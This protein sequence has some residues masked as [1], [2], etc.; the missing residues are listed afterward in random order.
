MLRCVVPC[1]CCKSCS[2][3]SFPLIRNSLH[4]SLSISGLLITQNNFPIAPEECVRYTNLTESDRNINHGLINLG[5]HDQGVIETGNWYRF[6]G[7]AGSRMLDT[8]PTG[9]CN[10]NYQGWVQDG[11]PSPGDV[12]VQRTV[13]KRGNGN[14]CNWPTKI[15]A[16]NCGNFIVYQ[17]IL[18]NC[19]VRYCGTD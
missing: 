7:P 1:T 4:R 13:C 8:C 18:L 2:A 15:I 16:T 19:Y 10:T 14:C 17:L 6:T 9:K 5:C 11:Q 3:V 12:R